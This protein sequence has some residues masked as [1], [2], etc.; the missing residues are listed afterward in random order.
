MLKML[1]TE[2]RLIW[3]VKLIQLVLFVI[4][5]R[6]GYVATSFLPE[7][8][9]WIAAITAVVCALIASARIEVIE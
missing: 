3:F 6:M 5:F 8:A 7:F 1:L 9:N 4:V 2:Q